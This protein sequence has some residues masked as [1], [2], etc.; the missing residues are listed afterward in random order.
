MMAFVV[1]TRTPGRLAPQRH[2]DPCHLSGRPSAM[3]RYRPELRRY[4]GSVPAPSGSEW[5]PATFPSGVPLYWHGLVPSLNAHSTA[6]GAPAV[7][8][9]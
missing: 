8:A 1:P 3:C 2:R 5:K 6:A 4:C 9:A 7:R